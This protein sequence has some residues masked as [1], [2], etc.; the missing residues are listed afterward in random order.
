MD[1]ALPYA[2]W[3]TV[4]MKWRPNLKGIHNCYENCTRLGRTMKPRTRKRYRQ[5]VI[6]LEAGPVGC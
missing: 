6:I 4:R 3:D 2:S 5:V 1:V